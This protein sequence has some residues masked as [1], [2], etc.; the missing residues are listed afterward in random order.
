VLDLAVRLLRLWY[1][2]RERLNFPRRVPAAD[3]DQLSHVVLLAGSPWV[4]WSSTSTST[5]V[6]ARFWV[7]NA[8]W[9]VRQD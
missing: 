6:P 8:T 7:T 2:L 4:I 9:P 5:T 3:F 1:V